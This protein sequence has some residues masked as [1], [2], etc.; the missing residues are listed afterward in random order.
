M[1]MVYWDVLRLVETLVLRVVIVE[2]KL[3][4]VL[5]FIVGDFHIAFLLDVWVL[6]YF[7][8]NLKGFMYAFLKY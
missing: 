6:F 5:V 8:R 3:H 7:V 4:V 2:V 1:W